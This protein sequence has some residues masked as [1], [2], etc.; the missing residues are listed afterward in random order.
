MTLLIPNL[1]ILQ[2]FPSTSKHVCIRSGKIMRRVLKKIANDET[3]LGD[4]STLAEPAV[5]Q[6][7]KYKNIS[8]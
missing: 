3:D 1:E 2:C 7:S 4:I 5:I 8:Y 6:V